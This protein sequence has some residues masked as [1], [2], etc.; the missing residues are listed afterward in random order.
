MERLRQNEALAQV[1][2]YAMLASDTAQQWLDK[3]RDEE[4][5]KGRPVQGC[6][7]PPESGTLAGLSEVNSHVVRAYVRNVKVGK[8]VTVD[9]DAQLVETEKAGA[10]YCYDGFKAFQPIEV[11][12]V[13]TRLVLPDAFREGNVP[14]PKE[15]TS[16]WWMRPT[17]LYHWAP[18]RCE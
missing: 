5:M 8:R 3:F 14:A 10:Q 1:L 2:S 15:T 7:L 13:E 18:G 17:R 12:W 16:V 4:L 6:F 11:C 9:I